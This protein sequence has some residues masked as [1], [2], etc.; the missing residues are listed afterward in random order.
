MTHEELIEEQDL[1]EKAAKMLVDK[2]LQDEQNK[3][4]VELSHFLANEPT[5]NWKITI[6]RL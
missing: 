5:S 6:E 2:V 3:M 1:L 4:F